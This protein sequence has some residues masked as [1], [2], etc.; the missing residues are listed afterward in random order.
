M[1]LV[2]F[3]TSQGLACVSVI[4]MLSKNIYSFHLDKKGTSWTSLKL[5]SQKDKGLLY[6]L[7]S[8]QLCHSSIVK[9]LPKAQRTQGLS[10]AYQS[11]QMVHITIS[12]TNLDQ[13]SSPE[14]LPSINFK[15]STKNQ[16]L[17]ST[18]ASKS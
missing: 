12:N 3:I 18:S 13:I 17:H 16:P 7:K 14:S 15:I 5:P 10:S 2:L 1:L 9:T 6:S 4:S 8:S 11:N